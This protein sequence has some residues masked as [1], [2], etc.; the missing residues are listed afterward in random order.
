MTYLKTT[1]VIYTKSGHRHKNIGR[2]GNNTYFIN[3]VDMTTE[4]I[5]EDKLT[6]ITKI[7]VAT[8]SNPLNKGLFYSI[9]NILAY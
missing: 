4:T 1:T 7:S 5:N 3:H 6:T 9:C 8:I 2:T